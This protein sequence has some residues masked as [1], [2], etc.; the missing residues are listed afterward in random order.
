MQAGEQKPVSHFTGR[1]RG[2]H[3]KTWYQCCTFTRCR[4]LWK[5]SCI[6]RTSTKG[7]FQP[8]LTDAKGFS[9][10][11]ENCC[12]IRFLTLLYC[13]CKMSSAVVVKIFWLLLDALDSMYNFSLKLVGFCSHVCPLQQKALVMS[14]E[15]APFGRLLVLLWTVENKWQTFDVCVVCL[16]MEPL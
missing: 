16:L 14:S 7:C 13:S 6:R 8:C 9:C 10:I 1:K 12:Y 11:L 2:R 4:L 3:H 15:P 5:I